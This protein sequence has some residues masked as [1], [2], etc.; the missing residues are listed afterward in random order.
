MHGQYQLQYAANGDSMLHSPAVWGPS[1]RSVES[2]LLQWTHTWNKLL[3]PDQLVSGDCSGH[4]WVSSLCFQRETLPRLSFTVEWAGLL[5][6]LIIMCVSFMAEDIVELT[7]SV[8]MQPLAE[9]SC[10]YSDGSKMVDKSIRN[11]STF[12]FITTSLYHI[13]IKL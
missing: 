8:W 3:I 11:A 7:R 4:N 2:N 10:L 1:G 12:N 6:F 9:V 13:E 5:A